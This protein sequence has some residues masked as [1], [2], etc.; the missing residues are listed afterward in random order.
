MK[1]I[2]GS[3]FIFFL[4]SYQSASAAL[5]T[6]FGKAVWGM[7]ESELLS[8]YQIGLNP[9]KSAN[10]DGVWA[11]EG[12]APGELTVSGTALGE[13]EIRSVSFGFHPKWGLSII[14][15]RFKEA[16]KKGELERLLPK[17]AGQY[18]PPK[19]QLPGPKV[20]WEDGVTHIELTYHIVSPIHPTPSDHLAMVLWSIPLMDKIEASEP[21][22]PNA[23]AP[24]VEKLE[25]MKKPH[26]NE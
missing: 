5:P 11:V 24:D 3:I 17:W 22:T 9:P 13:T 14:H 18:G 6:G 8:L 25:P 4:L 12:P 2:I 19:E 20:I 10:D 21:P 15:I 7:T 26:L 1:K 23:D 16:K